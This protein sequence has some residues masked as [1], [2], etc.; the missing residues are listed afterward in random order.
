MAVQELIIP[1]QVTGDD[2]PLPEYTVKIPFNIKSLF[3]KI[4]FGKGFFGI[5]QSTE[6]E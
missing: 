3:G 4:K 5:K 6:G 1:L 2:E